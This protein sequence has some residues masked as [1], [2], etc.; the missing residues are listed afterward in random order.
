[1]DFGILRDPGT[2]LSRTRRDG[3]VEFQMVI[4]AMEKIKKTEDKEYKDE[5]GSGLDYK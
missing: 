3:C 1:M 5:K 4:G 2:N